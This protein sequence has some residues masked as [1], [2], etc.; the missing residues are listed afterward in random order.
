MSEADSA[1]SISDLVKIISSDKVSRVSLLQGEGETAKSP[2]EALELLL[3]SAFPGHEKERGEY[4]W[5]NGAWDCDEATEK[6]CGYV[7]AHKVA[8][9][10]SSFGPRKAPGPDGWPPLVLQSLA[11]RDV[12]RLT[13]IIRTCCRMRQVLKEWLEM[14]VVFIPKLGKDTYSSPKSYRPIT[15]S[16]ITL[17]VMERVIQ[18]YLTEK[19]ISLPLTGQHAYT[20]GR[21]TET[22]VSEVTNAAERMVYRGKYLLA[23]SLD[24]VGAFDNIRYHSASRAM[25]DHGVPGGIISWYES[26]LKGRRI[27]AQL[28]GEESKI[29]PTRGSPQGG[30][31]S[32]LIW[33]LIM[34]SLLCKFQGGPVRA[35]GYADDVLLMVAGTAPKE[36][37]KFMQKALMAVEEWAR[38]QGLT[39]NSKKTQCILFSRARNGAPRAPRLK[40]NGEELKFSTNIK[41]L[42]VTFNRLLCWSHHIKER[43]KKCL[44]LLHK[45][46]SVVARDW[47]LS[48]RKVDWI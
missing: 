44:F 18:W 42:G 12:N 38:E 6:L 27:T 45:T 3:K 9:A 48:P 2:Q 20:Q 37:G 35:I 30:V 21:S 17:K 33:N 1:K 4:V 19:V 34:D 31:L 25:G 5:R 24:C 10:I 41:Y 36:I 39:F 26:V 47:G 7:D 13:E 8:E 16:N 14:R 23:V 29:I 15:L 46:K 40:L 11:E 28:Q 43:Y 22:A 32:P